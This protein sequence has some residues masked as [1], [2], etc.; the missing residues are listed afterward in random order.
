MRPHDW[1]EWG[2]GQ[3]LPSKRLVLNPLMAQTFRHS[4]T[5]AGHLQVWP[6]KV[7]T[8]AFQDPDCQ[9]PCSCPVQ[10]SS[11]TFSPKSSGWAL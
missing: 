8:H 5:P 3:E 6:L 4:I 10:S 9:Q 7:S 1:V 11:C 2:K